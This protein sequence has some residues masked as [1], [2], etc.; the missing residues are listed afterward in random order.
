MPK[1]A[2]S[3]LITGAGGYLGRQLVETL[4]GQKRTGKSIAALDLRETTPADRIPGVRYVTCDIRSP[5]LNRVFRDFAPDVVVHLASIVT[6]GKR[7]DRAFEYSVDVEGTEN[8]LKACLHASVRR[9]IVTSSGAAYGYH[10]DSPAWLAETDPLRGNPEFAY[11]DHKRLVEEMLERYR[12]TCP[13]LGQLVLRPGT[14]LG[15]STSN[16]ITA[17]FEK[18]FILGVRGA[19]IPFVFIWDKDVVACILKGIREGATGIFNLAGDGVLS[20]KEIARLLGKPYVPLPV[21]LLASALWLLKKLGMTQYGPEQ[22]NFLRYRPVLDNR[23]LK[24]EFGYIPEK[25]TR[26]VFEH[27]LRERGTVPGPA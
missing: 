2:V 12:K 24:E 18:P 11:S 20:M 13:Q 23:R 17:L 9:V 15:K 19:A 27:Y 16:Q 25:T 22:I 8:V 5:E 3:V 26:E 7:A 4:A 14:I 1:D 10:A 21:S 6:P